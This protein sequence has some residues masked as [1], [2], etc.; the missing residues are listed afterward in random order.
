VAK[1]SRIKDEKV[2]GLSGAASYLGCAEE[3][4]VKHANAGRL[5]HTRDTSGKRLFTLA[6]LQTFK[7]SKVIENN[8]RGRGG[9]RM[10]GCA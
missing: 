7:Q 3:T 2:F 1:I 6:D 8:R 9:S 10:Q 4:V 5:A